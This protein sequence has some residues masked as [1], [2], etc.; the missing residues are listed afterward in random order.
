MPHPARIVTLGDS[1][2]DSSRYSGGPGT[3]APEIL[4]RDLGTKLIHLARDG[5]TVKAVIDFQLSKL[6]APAPDTALIVS[7]G[8]NDLLYEIA[9][10]TDRTT[11]F[12][13]GMKELLTR[14]KKALKPE[15]IVVANVYDPS[16]HDPGFAKWIPDLERA[17]AIH[18]RYN[19]VI[20]SAA[21]TH[22]AT[23]VDLCTAFR[24]AERS[25]AWIVDRIEPS[26]AGARA[27]ASMFKAAIESGEVEA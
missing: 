12:S 16:K 20:A 14:A 9:A 11:E 15:R 3:S 8:G 2:L 10:N 26:A 22:G 18:A 27:I 5:H 23:L 1:V 17:L 4:A 25:P 24:S 7:V 13:K 6:P 21:A 19:E